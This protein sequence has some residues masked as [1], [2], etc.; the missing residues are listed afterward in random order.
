MKFA[1]VKE[2]DSNYNRMQWVGEEYL[3]EEVIDEAGDRF[4]KLEEVYAVSCLFLL[5]K[6]M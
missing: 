1:T 6:F 4:E 2:L 3:L 5:S